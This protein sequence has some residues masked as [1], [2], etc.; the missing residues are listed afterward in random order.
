M[1]RRPEWMRH[2]PEAIAT[3]RHLDAPVLDRAILGRLLHLQPR[4]SLRLMQAW[5]AQ[6]AGGALLLDHA[7]LLSRLEAIAQGDEFRWETRRRARLAERLEEARQDQAAR[8]ISVSV[9]RAVL[10]HTLDDLSA[11]IHLAPGQ[12]RIE[13]NGTEEL[14]RKL[15]ELAQAISR[16]FVRFDGLVNP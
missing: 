15:I 3:L 2:I 1:P 4:Q 6:P 8:Q 11:G 13:F 12:L 14:L 7:S 16:D 5:G 9:P 10:E